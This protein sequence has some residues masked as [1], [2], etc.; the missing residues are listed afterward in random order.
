META[1]ASAPRMPHLQGCE[2]KSAVSQVL[3]CKTFRGPAS[4][5]CLMRGFFIGP[6]GPRIRRARPS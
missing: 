6:N 3:G 4:F 2:E 1:D 5:S